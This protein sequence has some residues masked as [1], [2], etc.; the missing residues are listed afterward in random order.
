ML[1]NFL[2][3]AIC[4]FVLYAE[5]QTRSFIVKSPKFLP[6]LGSFPPHCCVSVIQL[7]GLCLVVTDEE[8]LYQFQFYK[9]NKPT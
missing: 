4:L 6:S 2:Q 1:F 3:E 5:A 7:R 9:I 8:F